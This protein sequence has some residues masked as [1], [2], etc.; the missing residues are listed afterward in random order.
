MRKQTE[1]RWDSTPLHVLFKCSGLKRA[2]VANVIDLKIG[3]LQA[4]MQGNRRPTE[5]TAKKLA[6]IF[7]V[8]VNHIYGHPK[9]EVKVHTKIELDT[10]NTNIKQPNNSIQPI[11]KQNL[12][13]SS[14]KAS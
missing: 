6:T 7:N 4:I 5:K 12:A 3:T 2:W 13:Q 10:C 14:G 1:K 8:S 11:R 9:E